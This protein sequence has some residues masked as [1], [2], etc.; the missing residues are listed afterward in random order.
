MNQRILIVDDEPDIRNI[1][2]ISL[3]QAGM[4][5][6]EASDGQAAIDIMH[7]CG[8]DLVVLD[9]GMPQMDGFECCKAIRLF[10]KVPILFLTAQGDEIDR[11]VGFELGCDDYVTKPFSP[12]E[13]KLRIKAILA[14]GQHKADEAI[15]VGALRIDRARHSCVLGGHDLTLTATEF[16]VLEML[17]RN[18][19]KVLDRNE[20]INEAYGGNSLLSGRTVDSHIRNIRAKAAEHGYTNIIETVRGVGLRLGSCI[21]EPGEHE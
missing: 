12:R 4:R 10:S 20:L 6:L 17:A 3:E 5:I 9:I 16:A 8:A 2:R 13:L 19:G 7:D 14:R 11:I 18:S 15:K 1:L 21:L